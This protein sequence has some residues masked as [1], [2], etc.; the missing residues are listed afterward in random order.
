MYSE[1]IS[2]SS[3]ED[4]SQSTQNSTVEYEFYNIN[5]IMSTLNTK[6]AIYNWC[7]KH[8]RKNRM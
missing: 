1:I 8:K 4:E 5:K 6:E 3:S 2:I 7:V